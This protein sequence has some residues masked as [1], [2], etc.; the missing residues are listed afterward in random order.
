MQ[1]VVVNMQNLLLGEAVAQALVANGEFH[2]IV[3]GKP[4]EVVNKCGS[5]APTIL[6]MEVTGC[7]PWLLPERMALQSEV[8]RRDP[9]CKIVL[10]V[11]E[12]AEKEAAAEIRQAKKDGLI[13]QFIYGSTSASY[14]AALMET[15]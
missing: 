10:L 13:D 12:N 4:Q 8:K 1:R 5:F 3:V 7:S 14:L 6:L 9:A 11:D 2:V 15:I